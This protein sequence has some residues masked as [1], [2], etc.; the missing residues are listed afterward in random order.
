MAIDFSKLKTS[1]EKAL[2][3]LTTL[4]V[5]TL[6]NPAKVSIDL[7]AGS[8]G[9]IFTAIRQNLSQADLV[10]YTRFDL[11]GDAV[12]YVS[13]SEEVTALADTHA[14]M[15]ESA[16]ETRKALFNTIIQI[17]KDLV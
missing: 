1:V 13:K 11:G 5:A 2:D 17:V 15:V 10:A 3:D 16:L 6:T 4:E 7:T 12:S 14:L 9:D 8:S